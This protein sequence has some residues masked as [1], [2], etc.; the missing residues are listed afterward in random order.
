MFPDRGSGRGDTQ[1]PRFNP[2]VD[3]Q[4]GIRT[5]SMLCVPLRRGSTILGVVEWINKL[6]SDVRV[7]PRLRRHGAD[8]H[9]HTRSRG[10]GV[11]V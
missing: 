8:T 5:K 6:D 1:H 11:R 10:D 4:T 7:G 3:A 9:T 2:A